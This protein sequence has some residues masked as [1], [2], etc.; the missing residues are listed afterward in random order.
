[1]KPSFDRYMKPSLDWLENPEVF[2]VN[3]LPAHS[4]HIAYRSMVE[5]SKGES[6]LIQKLDGEWRFSYCER[7]AERPADFYQ[8]DFDLSGF[9]T[10]RVPGHWETQGFGRPHYCNVPYP[11]DGHAELK[12]GEIDWNHDPVGS[13][14]C[15][16][17]LNEG[18]K[19][20]R[21][22]ISFQGVE[23]A[24]YLWLNGEFVGY[25][26]DTFTPSDFDLTPFIKETGNRLCVEVYKRSSA[27]WIEDQDF[28]RFGGIFRSVVLYAKPRVHLEDF[29]CKT[30]LSEDGT[31]SVSIRFRFSGELQSREHKGGELNAIEQKGASVDFTMCHAEDGVILQKTF[32]IPEEPDVWFTPEEILSKV[33]PWSHET[34]SLYDITFTVKDA[35]GEICEVIPYQVGF[36]RFERKG[37]TLLLNGE[38]IL[39][40][41]VNRHEWNPAKGRAI[42]REDMEKALAVFKRNNIN[43][44]RTSHYPN[45]TYWYE[46]CDQNGIYMIDETNLESH[47]SFAKFQG[48][49]EDWL[50]P[51]S[52]PEWREVCVDRARSMFERD[53]N[54]VAILFWSCGNESYGGEN[55]RAIANYFRGED[56]SRLV[57]YESVVY[58]P[59]YSDCTDVESRMYA[60]PKDIEE[61]LKKPDGK[62]FLSC[63]FE[64]CMGNAMG[65]LSEYFKLT[66]YE[67]YCGGFIWDFMDQAV[68]HMDA[69]GRR[70]LGYG[71]DFDDRLTD[72]AFSG[73]GITTAEGFEK[74][75]TQEIRYWYSGEA[76]R[77]E[78]DRRN[79]E[80]EAAAVLPPAPHPNGKI[81]LVDGLGSFSVQG[82]DFEVQFS[83]GLSGGPV[84]LVK[85][86]RE[87][88]FRAPTPVYWRP[89]THNDT[90]S[91][92]PSHSSMWAA[93]EKYQIGLFGGNEVLEHSIKATYNFSNPGI[94]TVKTQVIYEIF[95]DGR[96]VVHAAT[97]GNENNPQLLAYGMRFMTP[98]PVSEF[99][100]TGLSGETY[101]DLYRG[102][103]FGTW[104]DTPH[105][106]VHLVP[107]EYGCHMNTHVLTLNCGRQS[108][109]LTKTDKPFAFSVLPHTH[110]EIE[111]AEH[112]EELPASVRSVVS[113]YGAVRGVGGP[114]TG[115]VNDMPGC[116]IDGHE[117]QEV[118]F[119]IYL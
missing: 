24:F 85:G 90:F 100:W 68:Y 42:D 104:T 11:W 108:L 69:N 37:N 110:E 66:E 12:P 114:D 81:K 117:K 38:R 109:T 72:Y 23:E 17:D 46:L 115:G 30:A 59:E 99:T 103:I 13:Y 62:P 49:G 3:R 51:G 44:V 88:F 97:E 106:G 40:C 9:G 33:R 6:S 119:C 54:H 27:A 32:E 48:A 20:Q 70:V 50:V 31:G 87:W 41:G 5:A 94:P 61:Y 28:F 19:G 78:H 79:A 98:T 22:C 65:R 101:P 82:E 75:C 60:S 92:Q 15:E 93:A 76:A 116:F 91:A 64:H 86:G 63:E 18:L 84:S 34:P 56:S 45:Q 74:P 53:K 83:K 55:I 16:F 21:V 26:E 95:E 2:Q 105:K 96:M 14:V 67:N 39:F 77:A 52:H 107:Q 111:A 29:W 58:C 73:D 36:R 10:I 102:G 113:I 71:G 8:P 43:A 89:P 4:D 112:Q 57:H 80:A 1:M 118:E 35:S 25:S 47:G 7:P